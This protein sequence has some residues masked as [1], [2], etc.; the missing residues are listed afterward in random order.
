MSLSFVVLLV[1]MYIIS[2]HGLVV[3][4]MDLPI[5]QMWV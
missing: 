5:Q 1:V 4:T 3:S 2:S